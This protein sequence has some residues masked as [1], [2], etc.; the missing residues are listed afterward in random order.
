[1]DTSPLAVSPFEVAWGI[2][3]VT[4]LVALLATAWGVT[5]KRISGAEAI[6]AVVATVV[7]PIVGSLAVWGWLIAAHLQGKRM[8]TQ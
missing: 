7:V 2:Y 8:V 6:L 5:T 4:V 3:T 1:M